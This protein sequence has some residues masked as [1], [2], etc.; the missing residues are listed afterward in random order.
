MRWTVRKT[1]EASEV[2][3]LPVSRMQREKQ[4]EKRT[5]FFGKRHDKTHRPCCRR[6]VHKSTSWANVATLPS[7]RESL[8]GVPRLRDKTLLGTGW[9]RH[10]KIIYRPDLSIDPDIDSTKEQEQH[11][12][13]RRGR[14]LQ[15]PVHLENFSQS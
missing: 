4:E 9:I 3:S 14:L 1:H 8:T 12:N 10:L 5:S 7:A 11:L 13:P 6:C 15:H 2:L